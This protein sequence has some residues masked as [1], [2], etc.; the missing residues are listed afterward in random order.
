MPKSGM[1]S[2]LSA[3]C[4]DTTMSKRRQPLSFTY[5]CVVIIND[6]RVYV[7]PAAVCLES[8][9][10]YLFIVCSINVISQQGRDRKILS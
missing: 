5:W 1:G 7:I 2:A 3:L 9:F 6:D 8:I 10:V 4:N